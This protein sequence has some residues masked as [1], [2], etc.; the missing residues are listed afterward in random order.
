MTKIARDSRDRGKTVWKVIRR[1]QGKGD[2]VERK[3]Y[4]DGKE[5]DEEVAWGEMVE[6]WR[7]VCQMRVDNVMG[8][9]EGGLRERYEREIEGARIGGGY[10]KAENWE[11]RGL[12]RRVG[13]LKKG[14]S[15]GRDHVWGET[16]QEL[17][18][19]GFCRSVMVGELM[20]CME[21]KRFLVVGG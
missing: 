2:R 7:G 13:R 10:M 15:A 8:V 17:N 18:R 1:L 9:W 16:V 5:L 20:D 6:K 19:E 14:T 3:V 4:R 21:E 11:E 12:V